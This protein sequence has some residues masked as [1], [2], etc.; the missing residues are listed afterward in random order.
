MTAYIYETEV[1]TTVSLCFSIFLN[2]HINL[3]NLE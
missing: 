3:K 1:Q 2:Y